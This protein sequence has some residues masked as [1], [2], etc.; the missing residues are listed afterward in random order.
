MRRR[1]LFWFVVA[2]TG[3]VLLADRFATAPLFCASGFA[4]CLLLRKA[5]RPGALVSG[6]DYSAGAGIGRFPLPDSA[7]SGAE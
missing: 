1:P 5:T 6:R 3:G 4:A 2:F 7:N